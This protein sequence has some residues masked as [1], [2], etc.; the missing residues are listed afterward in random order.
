M[1]IYNYDRDTKEYLGESDAPID[2]MASKR[3]GRV[4]FLLPANATFEAPTIEASKISVHVD[5][6]WLN[7]EPVPEP[8]P[9]PEPTEEPIEVDPT[10]VLIQNEISL[11]LRETAIQRL[12]VKGL[13]TGKEV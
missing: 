8:I 3:E 11:F 2:P 4:V 7:V 1:K 9:E 6:K 12:T 5:G 13:L 10:E